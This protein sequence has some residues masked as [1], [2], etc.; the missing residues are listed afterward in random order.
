MNRSVFRKVA[1]FLLAFILCTAVFP[2]ASPS[3]AMPGDNYIVIDGNVISTGET[4]HVVLCDQYITLRSLPSTGA[5]PLAYVPLYSSVTFYA[6]AENGFC[7]VGYGGKTG[8]V[9]AQYLDFYEPQVAEYS[10][11]VVNCRQ[12]I[13]LRSMPSTSAPEICQMP[14]GARVTKLSWRYDDNFYLVSYG[15]F[16][17]Y[18]LKSYL[19]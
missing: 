1:V 4:A 17:G 18:A 11:Q 14:L 6:Q 13:T 15:G 3:Y 12:S 10:M 2:A 7:L 19:R 16:T 8:Y 5:A 9:L